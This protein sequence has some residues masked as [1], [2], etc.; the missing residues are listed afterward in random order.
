MHNFAPSAIYFN[1]NSSLS[2]ANLGN[3]DITSFSLVL[4]GNGNAL[5]YNFP[6]QYT[7]EKS[8]PPRFEPSQRDLAAAAHL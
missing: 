6:T 5:H 4:D 3:T 1:G 7:R 8:L 2:F